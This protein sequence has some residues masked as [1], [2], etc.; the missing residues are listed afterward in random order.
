MKFHA[1]PQGALKALVRTFRESLQTQDIIARYGGEESIILLP[2]TG[3]NKAAEAAERIRRAVEGTLI[4]S[5]RSLKCI[6]R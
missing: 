1:E 2:D 5:M 4:R 3:I 6:W